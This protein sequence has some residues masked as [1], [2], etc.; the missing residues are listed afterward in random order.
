M[1]KKRSA[2]SYLLTWS[3]P[4]QKGYILSIILAIIGVGCGVLPYFGISNIVGLVFNGIKDIDSYFNWLV[5]IA[6]GFFMQVILHNISTYISHKMTFTLIAQVRKNMCDKLAKLP[7]GNVLKRNSGELKNLIVEKVDAIEPTLAHL[8]P[9]MTSKITVPIIIWVI[10]MTMNWKIGLISLV[11]IPVGFAFEMLMMIGYEK[12]YGRYVQAQKNLNSVAVEYINGIEVI[13]T[14]NNSAKS[15]QKFADAAYEGAHS[16]IDW[17]RGCQLYFSMGMTTIP[18]TLL[19]VLPACLFYYLGDEIIIVDFITIIILSIGLA[20]PLI[21]A[22]S[23]S[24]DIGKIGTIVSDIVSILDEQE[25]I[26]PTQDVQFDHYN[27]K[28]NQVCFGY[29]DKEVLHQIDLEFK[30]N[31]L[32]ALVGPSGSGKST[33]TKLIASMWETNEGSITIGGHNIKDIPLKQ[34]NQIIAYVFQDNF[35]FDETVMEN[36]RKGNLNASDQE[37]IEMA[38]L[39]GCH[40]FI[41]NLENGYDTIV[42]GAGGHLSG[43][44]R[45]RV[46]I[47]RAMLKDAPIIVLDEATAYTDPE[48]EAIIQDSISRLIQGKTLIIVAHRLSTITSS[49]NI[50]VISDGKVHAQGTHQQLLDHDSLYSTLYQTHIGTK[51][52]LEDK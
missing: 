34:L 44:E 15:Y 6:G 39:S 20:P 5:L 31:S 26:R 51:R 8:V 1:N 36:I 3:K 45:Q 47:A 22:I 38:K 7:M 13:K 11:T 30:E 37:V 35:L 29:G 52:G 19:T 43:G 18:A 4:Y 49:D 25:L 12:R 10:I 40:E 14:F 42:G 28:L 21:G 33:I 16:A 23:F 17:M 50:I 27:I 9:E 2:F 32:S 48:N 24:D 46:A 41:M